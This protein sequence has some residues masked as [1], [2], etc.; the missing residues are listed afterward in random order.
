MGGAFPRAGLSRY[1]ALSWGL[2]GS[3]EAARLPQFTRW[4]G[5]RVVT[6]RAGAHIRLA[7]SRLSW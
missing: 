4:R 6:H 3:N 2:G 1:N 7:T 5:G